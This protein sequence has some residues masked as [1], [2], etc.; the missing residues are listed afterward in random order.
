M[1]I[2][3]YTYPWLNGQSVPECGLSSTNYD[4]NTLQGNADLGGQIPGVAQLL[5]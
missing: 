3:Y 5:L 2:Q 1:Q 4:P